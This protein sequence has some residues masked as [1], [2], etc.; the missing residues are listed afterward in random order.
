MTFEFEGVEWQGE[1]IRVPGDGP[2]LRA[3]WDVRGLEAVRVVDPLEW[4]DRGDPDAWA[5]DHADA[6]VQFL[7]DCER[8]ESPRRCYF[9]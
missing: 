3:V 1:L 4:A 2:G 6:V 8:D 7:L 5:R 9:D